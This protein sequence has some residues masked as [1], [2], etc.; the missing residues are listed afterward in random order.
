MIVRH[1]CPCGY[2][3]SLISFTSF[4]SLP[5][6]KIIIFVLPVV[7]VATPTILAKFRCLSY[8][9]LLDVCTREVKENEVHNRSPLNLISLLKS[10]KPWH[11]FAFS[12][13][14][15]NLRNITALRLLAGA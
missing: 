3:I 13:F 9:A 1:N 7:E 11:S 10:W 14:A 5:P 15:S 12:D 8:M 6:S 2:G 4:L